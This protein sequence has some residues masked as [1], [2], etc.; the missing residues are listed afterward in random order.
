VLAAAVV[1]HFG[2]G[3]TMG[4]WTF[5]LAMLIGCASFLPAQGVASLLAELAPGKER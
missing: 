4:L 3:A 5:S 2:V 1:L